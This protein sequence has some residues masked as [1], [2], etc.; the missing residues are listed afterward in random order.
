MEGKQQE[1]S[2]A[3]HRERLAA[4]RSSLAALGSALWQ[5]P[6]GGGPD[7]LSGLLSEVDALGMACETG[8]IAE[9]TMR[10]C[11]TAATPDG[12][13][14]TPKGERV[15]WDLTRCCY[16]ELLARRVASSTEAEPA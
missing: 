3:E 11:T 16:D 8:R 4:A 7:R 12:S 9:R 1:L 6:S 14:R 10:S 15:E 5:V 2:P 13:S